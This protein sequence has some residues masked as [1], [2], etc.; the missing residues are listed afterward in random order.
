MVGAAEVR[1]VAGGDE[2]MQQTAVLVAGGRGQLGAELAT[3]GAAKAVALVHAPGSTELD[4][5][6]RA[7]VVDA[8]HAFAQ[9]ARDTGRRPVVINAAAYTAVDAAETDAD[10]AAEVNATSAGSLSQVCHSR[11]VPLIHVSTDY[12]FSGD[13][14][15][16]YEPDDPT[17]PRTVYGRT[18]LDGERA[19]LAANPHAWVVRTAWVYGAAGGNFVKTMARLQA[20]RDTVSVVDDQ[21]GSPTWAGDLAGGLLELAER[22]ARRAG[23]AQRVLHCTNSGRASWFDFARA[24][25][26]EL[27]ADPERVRPCSSEQFPRPA[28]R[29]AFSVLSDRAWGEAGLAPLRPW[30]DA[31]AAAFVEHGAELRG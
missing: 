23:P 8:V 19:V 31:L 14:G 17:G 3:I 5:T 26:T 13:S 12:V 28:P 20:E 2:L 10:R 25:F 7:A 6:D 9:A 1:F 11:G 21:V 4:I 16:P 27:G 30:R 18:K 24:V 22:V 29:P 15:R